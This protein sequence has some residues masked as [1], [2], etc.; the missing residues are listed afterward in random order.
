MTLS[1]KSNKE[2]LKEVIRFSTYIH[3]H[4]HANNQLD[5]LCQDM[6]D[7]TQLLVNYIKQML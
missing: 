2:L 1:P 5:M 7:N 6:R 4:I 3:T